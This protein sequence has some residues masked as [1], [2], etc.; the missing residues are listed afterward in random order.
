MSNKALAS[1]LRAAV[2]LAMSGQIL[3]PYV[4]L[5]AAIEQSWYALHIAKDPSPPDRS[6][7]WLNRNVDA[8]SKER[9]KEEFTARR[10]RVTHEAL[11]AESA[12]R[13]HRLYEVTI[14]FGAHPNSAGIL[15][16]LTESQ[17]KPRRVTR[18]AFFVRNPCR[19]RRH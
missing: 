19:W 18:W 2:R 11:D 6:A 14:N 3:E 12:G 5:R 17:K 15:V 9:C 10:V 16:S 4:L 8:E 7:L 1:S 13:L